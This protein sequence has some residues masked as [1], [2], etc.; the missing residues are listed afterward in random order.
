[1]I[2]IE[3]GCRTP[4]GSTTLEKTMMSTKHVLSIMERL[5]KE[6]KENHDQMEGLPFFDALV[7]GGLPIESYVGQLKAMAIVHSVLEHEMEGSEHKAVAAVREH[8]LPKLPLLDEDLEYFAPRNI[9]DFKTATQKALKLAQNIKLAHIQHPISILGY[10]YV[11]EGSTLGN[12]E[13]RADVAKTFDLQDLEG[14][15]YYSS[16]KDRLHENWKQFGNVMNESVISPEDQDQIVSAARNA[17]DGLKEIYKEL[18]PVTDK[19]MIRHVTSLNPEAGDHPIATDPRE[20]K[21]LFAPARSA[22]RNFLIMSGAIV[23]VGNVLQAVIVHG[24]LLWS[25]WIRRKFKS[26]STGW[27]ACSPKEV[28]LK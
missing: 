17:F 8:R 28:C 18:Y 25:N 16:Y 10:F 26:K 5:R 3:H 6:T 13:H 14:L 21:R 12:A 19:A 22:G 23:P 24:S 15:S 1:M 11:F 4:N 9:P 2:G 20:L 27:G 7:A